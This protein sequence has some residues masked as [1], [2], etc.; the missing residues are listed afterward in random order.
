MLG[1][2]LRHTHK[3]LNPIIVLI[4]TSVNI[5]RVGQ[6]D[7]S[8]LIVII[9]LMSNHYM[10]LQQQT[11]PPH[12]TSR[13][14]DRF[15]VYFVLINRMHFYVAC[16]IFLHLGM[17]IENGQQ[18]NRPQAGADSLQLTF[19]TLSTGPFVIFN[20]LSQTE[21]RPVVLCLHLLQCWLATCVVSFLAAGDLRA[22]LYNAF[23]ELERD[24]WGCG[25]Q[26]K[27]PSEV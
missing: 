23:I 9:P 21:P 4:E 6:R 3:Y 16:P 7:S 8:Y 18:K 27:P 24:G 19:L 22:L 17:R 13:T 1:F 20:V 10:L 15:A 12:I 5:V 11:S 26:S 2:R 25:N 14:S